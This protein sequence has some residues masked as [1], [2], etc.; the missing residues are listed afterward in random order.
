MEKIKNLLN[1]N[2]TEDDQTLHGSDHSTAAHSGTHSGGV[3]GEGSHLGGASITSSQSSNPVS[4]SHPHT[5]GTGNTGLGATTGQSTQHGTHAGQGSHFPSATSGQTS[6]LPIHNSGTTTTTTTSTHTGQSHVGRDA[7]LAGAGATGAGLAEHGHQGH[8]SGLGSATTGSGLGH[9]Q[10]SGISSGTTSGSHTSD[11]ANRADSRVDSDNSRNAG[12]GSATTGSGYGHNQGTTSGPH[13]SNLANRADPRVDSDNSRNAGLGSVTTGSG[14]GHNQ[15]SGISSG[16]TSGPHTSDLANR[17]DPRVDSDNSRNAGLGNT[18]TGATSGHSALPGLA[19]SNT[20]SG[21]THNAGVLSSSQQ[22][23]G[24][25]IDDTDTSRSIGTHLPGASHL[26]QTSQTGA[27]PNYAQGASDHHLGRDAGIVGAGA[28]GAG[29]HGHNHQGRDAGIVGAGAL[30]ASAHGHEHGLEHVPATSGPHNT[31]AANMLD[32]SVNTRATT[33]LEDA[34]HHTASGGGAEE[35]DA[36]HGGRPTESALALGRNP[37]HNKQQTGTGVGLGSSTGPAPHTAG[38]HQ[39]DIANIVDPRVNPNNAAGLGA[40]ATSQTGSHTT[41]D[42]SGHHYGRDATIGAGGVGAAG[43]VGSQHH[44]N[45]TGS[46]IGHQNTS[47]THQSAT[48][49]SGLPGIAPH[50]AGPHNSD[51]LNKADPRV[52][53][54]PTAGQGHSQS[55][56]GLGHH[57]KSHHADHTSLSH[58]KEHNYGRDAALAGGATS[59]FVGSGHHDHSTTSGPTHLGQHGASTTSQ[60]AYSTS[61]TQRSTVDPTTSRSNDHRLGRDAAVAGGAA[62]VGGVAAHEHDKHKHENELEKAQREAEKE[63]KHDLKQAEKDHKIEEKRA[64]KHSEKD[65][66]HVEKEKKHGFLSFLHRDK[67]KKY[68]AEEEADFERQEREHHASQSHTGRNAA[69]GTTVVGG[70]ALD[71]HHDVDT[72]KALPTAPG[73]HGVGTGAGT[74]NALAG[75]NSSGHDSATQGTPLPLKPAG[76]D[77]GDILH[78][79]ER[80]RGV[81]GASGFSNEPGFGDGTHP[82]AHSEATT[83]QSGNPVGHATTGAGYG[84]QQA[85]RE[86]P[87]GHSQHGATHTDNDSPLHSTSQH[88]NTGR[89]TAA[90][91]GAGLVGDHEHRKHD[92]TTGQHSGLTGSHG[93]SGLSSNQHHSGLTG[94]HEPS[95]LSGNQQHSGLTGSHGSSGLSGNQT[96]SGYQTGH[97]TSGLGSSTGQYDHESS[98]LTGSNTS[99]LSGRNKLHKDP[100]AGHPAAQGYGND[101]TGAH[102]PAGGAERE[103]FVEQGKDHLG[104]DT[105]VANAQNPNSSTN[106]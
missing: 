68:S 19:V 79:V 31:Y 84:S 72:N 83:D 29:T 75:H 96:T 56:S 101:S 47:N 88:H 74:Q 51:L 43:L 18:H 70:V 24:E 46:G 53:A 71:V 82:H 11:L 17:A 85:G 73:N 8:Q 50:T 76:R 34:H 104:H 36:Q 38:P 81:T 33:G 45:Q 66:K 39:K 100:P 21:N 103:R 64:E 26:P 16:T 59:A 41:T 23:P 54:N 3:S 40:Q 77:I 10:S 62:G 78:G 99:D 25:W 106:Y 58:E 95:A 14:F 61:S 91:G 55:Q 67:S 80:N 2:K 15:S 28:L 86:F 69:V 49:A 52:E 97:E 35:A 6:T 94:S 37:L 98:G 60:D 13:T 9:N 1:L 4:S 93:T 22:M 20:H 44:N 5:S 7:G 65:H 48:G 87:L 32:P 63:H 92:T 42:A 90:L 105:G 102:V 27:N 57:E 30:G 12:L 89:D